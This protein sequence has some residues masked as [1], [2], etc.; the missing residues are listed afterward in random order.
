M[1]LGARPNVLPALL[2]PQTGK[3][4][5]SYD[6]YLFPDQATTLTEPDQIRLF[7]DA[8]RPLH[9]GWQPWQPEIEVPAG[10][11]DKLYVLYG[12]STNENLVTMAEV[13]LRGL[14]GQV[15]LP[16]Y[17]PT[18]TPTP[19]PTFTP[20]RT[21][22]FTPAVSPTPTLTATPT[23]TPSPTPI[24]PPELLLL[25]DGASFTVFNQSAVRVDLINV[26]FVGVNFT[27]SGAWW[28]GAVAN[29]LLFNFAP[30]SCVVAYSSFV[31]SIPPDAPAQCR[32]TLAVRGNLRENQRFWLNGDFDVTFKN[33][34]LAT[35]RQLTEGEP[36]SCEVD[37]PTLP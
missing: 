26:S 4:S 37:F 17:V 22:T 31:S 28:G 5:L 21:P 11:G 15:L 9:D 35:C 8:G 33:D 29:N 10:A 14:A 32:R 20:T 1:V 27:L 16:G 18:R 24:P 13:D 34:L 19:S 2:N 25:Y 6:P 3:I 7:D 36:G 30:G 12:S 23:L